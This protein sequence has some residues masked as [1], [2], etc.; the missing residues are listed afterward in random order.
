MS[1]EFCIASSLY[2]VPISYHPT[3]VEAE[4]ALPATLSVV[5]TFGADLAWR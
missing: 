2:P 1:I 5:E 4:S 3:E